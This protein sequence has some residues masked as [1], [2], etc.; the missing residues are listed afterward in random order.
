V[1][2]DDGIDCPDQYR[3]DFRVYLHDG[4]VF[5]AVRQH[6]VQTEAMT[7]EVVTT[8]EDPELLNLKQLEAA[9]AL[10][11]AVRAADTVV[12][13][14]LLEAGASPGVRPPAELPLLI[15]AAGSTNPAM[16]ALLLEH[17]ADPNASRY[18]HGSA[19]GAAAR[20]GDL[21]TVKLLVGSGATVDLHMA[22]EAGVRAPEAAT[23]LDYAVWQGH[24]EVA[25]F[26]YEEGARIAHLKDPTS[27]YKLK[28]RLEVFARLALLPR[29][30]EP[31]D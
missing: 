5:D 11:A 8:S 30:V 26:L 16:V 17:K 23:A 29:R 15:H 25:K 24:F 18:P 19:L 6:G 20:Q 27:G 9:E 4:R 3:Y 12:V 7:A 28:E 1:K 21:Q 14:G 10:Y 13:K 22:D 2:A 31:T